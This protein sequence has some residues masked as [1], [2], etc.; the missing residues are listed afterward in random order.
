MKWKKQIKF[1]IKANERIMVLLGE[2]GRQVRYNFER[3]SMGSVL[4]G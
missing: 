3:K 1:L 4:S 2:G